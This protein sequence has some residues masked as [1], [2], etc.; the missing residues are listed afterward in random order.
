[1]FGKKKLSIDFDMPEYELLVGKAKEEGKS[2]SAIV[3]SLIRLF[4]KVSPSVA[5]QVAAFCHE[6]YIKEKNSLEQSSGFERAEIENR[7]R[8][9]ERL[10]EYFGYEAKENEPDPGMRITFLKEGY[11]VYPDDWIRLDNVFG[12][13]E[14]CMYAGCVESR[15]S[16]KLGIPHFIFF[17]NVKSG[18]EYTDE[19]VLQVYEACAKAYPDFKKYYNA[20]MMTDSIGSAPEDPG[21]WIRLNEWNE[22]PYFGTFP[23]V[24]KGDP[25]YWN[26]YTPDYKPPYGAMIIRSERKESETHKYNG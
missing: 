16:A 24:E 7:I 11:V 22:R 14:T 12:P 5:D 26:K 25:I 8:E 21:Y 3:N 1:M 23:I 4:A 13:A 15:N 6:Q 18:K 17:C 19:M 20:Q 2:N 9:Y 10:S